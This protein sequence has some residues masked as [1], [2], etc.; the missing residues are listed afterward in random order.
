MREFM[1]EKEV[2]PC[3]IAIEMIYGAEEKSAKVWKLFAKQ[4]FSEAEGDYR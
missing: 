4:I 3:G 2:A 1:Y